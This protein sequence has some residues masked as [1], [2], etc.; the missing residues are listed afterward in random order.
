MTGTLSAYRLSLWHDEDTEIPDDGLEVRSFSTRHINSIHPDDVDPDQVVA[1]LSYYEHGLGRWSRQFSG[2]D[3]PWDT[4]GYAGVLVKGPDYADHWGNETLTDE[5][6]DAYLETYTDWC[7]G[8]CY[9]Y[10]LT[11]L[12]ECDL[13]ET[14]EVETLDSCGGFIGTEW[15]VETVREVLGDLNISVEDLELNDPYGIAD[16]HSL[17]VS[18]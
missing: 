5:Q 7:N 9:G 17:E 14:H 16:I 11:R 13:G 15:L 10:T 18:A 8:A 1:R 6:V 3:D 4:V 12:G 2:P